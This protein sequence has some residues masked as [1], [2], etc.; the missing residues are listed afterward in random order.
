MIDYKKLI[1]ENIDSDN[2]EKVIEL[3]LDAKEANSKDLLFGIRKGYINLFRASYMYGTGYSMLTE[4]LKEA[5]ITTYVFNS[6][7]KLTQ[8]YKKGELNKDIIANEYVVVLTDKASIATK[9]NF[10]KIILNEFNMSV[11]A[12]GVEGSKIP[13]NGNSIYMVFSK[14]DYICKL[15]NK[16][17]G[18][19]FEFNI[20]GNIF[21]ALIRS[22]KLKTL[23]K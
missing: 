4:K 19:K 23:L 10:Y 21:T 1:I 18:E 11:K 13:H 6:Q 7:S 5:G 12:V 9:L 8:A 2:W 17:S 22:N 14:Y 3:A 16:N 15:K 20:E